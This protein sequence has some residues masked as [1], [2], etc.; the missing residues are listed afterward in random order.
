MSY[1]S[2]FKVNPDLRSSRVV[3]WGRPWYHSFIHLIP[4]VQTQAPN[5]ATSKRE[6][7]PYQGNFRFIFYTMGGN[8]NVSS[9]FYNHIV[10][11]WFLKEDMRATGNMQT[12]VAAAA[13][14]LISDLSG[15][16][17]SAAHM[18]QV[19]WGSYGQHGHFVLACLCV[20]VCVC[21]C[22]C[23]HVCVPRLFTRYKIVFSRGQCIYNMCKPVSVCSQEKTL[24]NQPPTHLM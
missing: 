14:I 12:F 11:Q 4:T 2:W 3:A 6:L 24:L 19:R 18:M 8:R 10:H 1:I 17:K 22:A 7:R 5:D 16:D 20:C 15:K 21:A 13:M 23:V 9:F